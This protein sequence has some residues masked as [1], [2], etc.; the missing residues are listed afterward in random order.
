MAKKDSN[1]SKTRAGNELYE[2]YTLVAACFE[3]LGELFS[4]IGEAS[5]KPSIKSVCSSGQ[6]LADN[7]LNT[8]YSQL[9]VVAET[10][11]QKESIRA[12]LHERFIQQVMGVKP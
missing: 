7:W 9:D 2:I 8:V 1:S 3:D 4:V 11:G 12:D 5:E 10:L 6:Y